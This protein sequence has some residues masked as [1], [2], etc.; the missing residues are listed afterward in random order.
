MKRPTIAVCLTIHDRPEDV[1]KRVFDSLLPQSFDQM[2]VVL[3]RA[4]SRLDG[5]VRSYLWDDDRIEIVS[6][7]GGMGWRCPAMAWN[8]AFGRVRTELVYCLS[9][10]TIQEPGSVRAAA[11]LLDGPPAIVFG[12]AECSCGP[13]GGEVNW[14]GTAPS[15]L[16]CDAAHPRPLGFIWAGPMW[17]IRSI[18]G[19]DEGFMAGHWYDDNDFFFRLWN[20]GIPFVFTD[21]IG[22]LHLHHD[23]HSLSAETIRINHD[24]IVKKW[25]KIPVVQPVSSD[26]V[27]GRPGITVWKG[28]I[29]GF[30]NTR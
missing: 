15:N 17:A 5:F 30:W 25:G 13:D 19:Y 8:T 29:G 11:E 2:V 3:D 24:Y 16:L 14:N 28:S 26:A 23:R 21:R 10:E 7:D 4:P 18:G 27:I 12:R 22:G 9:S 1:L 6:I 20:L